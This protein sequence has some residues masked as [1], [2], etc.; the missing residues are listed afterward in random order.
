MVVGGNSRTQNRPG[1][2]KRAVVAVDHDVSI[3]VTQREPRLASL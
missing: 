2:V 1:I 3:K